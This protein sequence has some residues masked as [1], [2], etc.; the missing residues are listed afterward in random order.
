MGPFLLFWFY[1]LIPSLLPTPLFLHI[2]LKTLLFGSDF[3]VFITSYH[4][5]RAKLY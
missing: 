3:N 1:L 5:G 4:T 2:L